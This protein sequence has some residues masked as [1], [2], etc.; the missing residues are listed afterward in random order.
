MQ[1]W[2]LALWHSSYRVE[3]DHALGAP[4]GSVSGRKGLSTLVHQTASL[5]QNALQ[6]GQGQESRR[7][8]LQACQAQHQLAH[9]SFSGSHV[10]EGVP[11]TEAARGSS[12]RSNRQDV[13][14]C[15][16]VFADYGTVQLPDLTTEPRRGW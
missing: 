8:A 9:A 14:H 4:S 1:R 3:A 2:H 16:R 13:L 15:R 11:A 5:N 10:E 6:Q 12:L 7:C